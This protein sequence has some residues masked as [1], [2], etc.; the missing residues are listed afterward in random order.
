M[1]HNREL[2]YRLDI[3][4]LELELAL[5]NDYDFMQRRIEYEIDRT[6]RELVEIRESTPTNAESEG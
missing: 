6:E 3:L 1:N 5:K 4:H 2:L